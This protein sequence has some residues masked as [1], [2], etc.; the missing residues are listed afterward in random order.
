[1][2]KPRDDVLERES[3]EFEKGRREG[4][5]SC[6]KSLTFSSKLVGKLL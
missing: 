2:G 5:G 3:K 6:K 4:E 1:M